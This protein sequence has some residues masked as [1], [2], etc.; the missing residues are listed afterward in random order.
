MYGRL[1]AAYGWTWRYDDNTIGPFVLQDVE[2]YAGMLSGWTMDGR[3]CA[4]PQSE[5]EA[6]ST[7]GQEWFATADLLSQVPQETTSRVRIRDLPLQVA[8]DEDQ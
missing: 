1:N 4:R 5:F 6:L 8:L 3:K 7:D 2:R